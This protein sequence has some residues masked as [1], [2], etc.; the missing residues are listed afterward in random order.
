MITEEIINDISTGIGLKKLKVSSKPT[1]LSKDNL[2]GFEFDGYSI[3]Y[4]KINSGER[5]YEE[6]IKAGGEI[7]KAIREIDKKA[8]ENNANTENKDDKNN[9]GLIPVVEIPE[10]FTKSDIDKWSDLSVIDRLLM[11]Q[12]TPKEYIKYKPKGKKQIPYVEGNLM[13]REAN[14]VFLF[15]WHDKIEGYHFS[16][17]AVACYGF[18]SANINGDRIIHSAVGIDL[19]EFT[20]EGN[21][22]VF[23]DEELMKNAHTDMIKK[24][25]S[26]FGFNNDVYRGEV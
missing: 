3:K 16:E 2:E 15:N 10:S 1:W 18:V 9:S 23:T 5:V 24:A 12:N 13:Q 6:H 19:Q 22:P 21:K 26:K 11:V 14:F 17:R 7:D 8:K 4:F 20:K 25:L